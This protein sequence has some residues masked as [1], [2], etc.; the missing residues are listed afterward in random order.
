MPRAEVR[1]AELFEREAG[2]DCGAQCRFVCVVAARERNSE[3]AAV[4]VAGASH[5]DERARRNGRHVQRRDGVAAHIRAACAHANRY[6]RRAGIQQRLRHFLDVVA[7]GQ[8]ARLV[9][10][11]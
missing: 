8:L 3:A 6:E 2:A 9:D 10:V 1:H 11:R 4:G 5:V 7:F